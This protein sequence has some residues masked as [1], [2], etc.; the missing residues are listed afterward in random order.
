MKA[1]V[2]V[3]E[4]DIRLEERQIPIPEEGEL[5][6]QVKSVAICGTD[7]RMWRGV[8]QNKKIVL[9]HEIAGI[10]SSIGEKTKGYVVGER[11]AVAPNVGCG[12]CDQCVSGR[13]HLCPDYRALGIN[14]DGGFAEYVRIPREAVQQGN[15]CKLDEH[16]S[17]SEAAAVE[18]LSCVYNAFE[19][20]QVHPGDQVLVIG[21]GPIGCMHVMLAQMAGASKVI[22]SDL[23]ADRLS[24]CKK[25]LPNV[26]TYCGNDL[27]HYINQTTRGHG[28][29]V[30]VT[31][32]PSAKAQAQAPEMM[33]M[34]GRICFFGG[35][36]LNQEPVPLNTNLIH[37]RHLIVT[38]TSRSSVSQYRKCLQ[39]VSSGVLPLAQLIT[40]HFSLNEIN[41]AFHFV[42]EAN[43]L[44][45]VIDFD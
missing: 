28:V 37:Y 40:H 17:F 4:K 39:L 3:G 1:G 29:D 25:L 10:V 24:Y 26:E 11:V 16:I 32:C 14:M 30:C 20:Y 19:H 18:P 13:T 8:P 2:W 23:S 41:R 35:L 21:A 5:I 36:P 22:L 6:L 7:I 9:G 42:S 43:G 38:G 45:S 15:V 44:K 34:F 27:A 12:I 31:A 33:A